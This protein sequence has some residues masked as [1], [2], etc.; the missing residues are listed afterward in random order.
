MNSGRMSRNLSRG[1]T[2]MIGAA[3]LAYGI[4]KLLGTEVASDTIDLEPASSPAEPHPYYDPHH[5]TRQDE[6]PLAKNHLAVSRPH[7]GNTPGERN[8]IGGGVS[9]KKAR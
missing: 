5:H 6:A 1:V 9:G 7:R 4:Y 2:M 3:A 8:Q